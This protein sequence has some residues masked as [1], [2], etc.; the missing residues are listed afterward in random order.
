MFSLEP[1]VTETCA[2]GFAGGVHSEA[3]NLSFLPIC[4]YYNAC[5]TPERWQGR[6][7]GCCLGLCLSRKQRYSHIYLFYGAQD[8]NQISP[9]R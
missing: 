2:A 9:Q 5:P 8:L 7:C 1:G 4:G 3:V 6:G